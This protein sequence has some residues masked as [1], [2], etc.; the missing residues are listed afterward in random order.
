MSGR[1]IDLALGGVD[2]PH[3]IVVDSSLVYEYVI[4]SYPDQPP[5]NAIRAAEFFRLLKTS[6]S[7]AIVTPMI[8]KEVFHLLLRARCT[9]L[10]PAYRPLLSQQFPW[11][12]PRSF[13]W[14][15]VYKFDDRLVQQLVPD[16]RTLKSLLMLNGVAILPFQEID[17]SAFGQ[18]WEE[19]LIDGVARYGLD[20]YDAMVL[21]EARQAGI[22]SIATLD[23][24]FQRAQIDFD[25]Y[26]WL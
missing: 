7:T 17:P 8:V 22:F 12:K 19:T 1:V 26:T 25:V 14:R 24:D 4:A 10:V 21:L 18:R 5:L 16:L 9:A 23:V 20:T 3:A 15:D 6:G 2:L 11:R 13:N